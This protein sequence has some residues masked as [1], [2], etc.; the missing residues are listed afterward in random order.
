MF[1][2]AVQI[3]QLVANS[4]ERGDSHQMPIHLGAAA[5][6]RSHRSRN[7][8]RAVLN[9]NLLR[10]KQHCQFGRLRVE[11]KNRLHRRLRR[12]G[13]N[14]VRRGARAKRKAKRAHDNGFARAR[15]AAER[16]EARLEFDIQL[17]D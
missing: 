8:Q 11:P 10:I 6:I 7:N 15:F 1:M 14:G 12:V 16:V 2:L 17:L 3:N 9:G 13:A 4:G 5:P